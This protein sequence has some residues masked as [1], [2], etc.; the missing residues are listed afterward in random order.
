[1]LLQSGFNKWRLT[2]LERLYKLYIN[3]T[4]TRVLQIYKNDYNEYKNKIFQKIHT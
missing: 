1:M 2:Q 3:D 4:S